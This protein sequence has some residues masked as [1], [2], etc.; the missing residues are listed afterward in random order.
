YPSL[1]SEF[2]GTRIWDEEKGEKRKGTSWEPCRA[3]EGSEGRRTRGSFLIRTPRDLSAPSS[4]P[5]CSG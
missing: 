1:S 5:D 3:R 4:S 2:S